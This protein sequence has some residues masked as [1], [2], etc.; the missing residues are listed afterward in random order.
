MAKQQVNTH[1]I[2]ESG[3]QYLPI[4]KEYDPRRYICKGGSES[5]KEIKWYEGQRQ[6][7]RSLVVALE[8]K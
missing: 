2:G 5:G 4:I 3:S 7:I 1:K 8:R 6:L